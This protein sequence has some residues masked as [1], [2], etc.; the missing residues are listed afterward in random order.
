M[1][2]TAG[3]VV[4]V[5]LPDTQKS[6]IGKAH[7]IGQDAK[8]T[9][10]WPPRITPD[11]H[12]MTETS[13]TPDQTQKPQQGD[14]DQSYPWVL[15]DST[16]AGCVQ[17]GL[18]HFFQDRGPIEL[19]IAGPN[20]GRNVTAIFAL[21]SGTLGA[22][23]EASVCGYRAIALSFAFF[24]RNHDPE[25]IAESCTQGMRVCEWLARNARW[26]GAR[27]YSINVPVRKG[28]SKNQV[29]WT[30]MLQNQWRRGA[31]FEELHPDTSVDDPSSE[32]AKLREQEARGKEGGSTTGDSTTSTKTA[33]WRE[34][35]F[36]WAPR[37]ADVHESVE[38]GGPGTD[39]WVIKDGNT[40][41][42]ALKANFMHA[43][44]YEGEVKL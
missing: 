39:G 14:D 40:S 33:R 9:F 22:A 12:S 30:K 38:S 10:Y 2:E 23:L 43:D 25:I 44:G 19:V 1:L 28:T 31:C 17:I 42:T 4:S 11:E 35:H 29:I 27:L 18:S 20:Y 5:I 41:V 3:H 6:W 13:S 15:V 21:S 37:F 26:D 32:E 36:K 8:A 34:R 7:M 16:P 24:D